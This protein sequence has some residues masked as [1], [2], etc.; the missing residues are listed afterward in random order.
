M[1]AAHY[2]VELCNNPGMGNEFTHVPF[3]LTWMTDP[4]RI[5][6]PM[7]SVMVRAGNNTGGNGR[8]SEVYLTLGHVNPPV[9]TEEQAAEID[10]SVKLPVVVVGEFVMSIDR[11]TELQG[12]LASFLSAIAED[13]Q[14]SAE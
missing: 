12:V 3:D 4:H 7:T 14:E 2:S 9:L 5:P 8:P 11:L 13:A 1:V 6:S 10:G